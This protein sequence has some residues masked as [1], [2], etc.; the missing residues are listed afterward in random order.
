MSV[1]RSSTGEGPSSSA[2]GGASGRLSGP[3]R[4]SPRSLSSGQLVEVSFPIAKGL[5]RQHASGGG[6]RFSR[7]LSCST[8]VVAGGGSQLAKCR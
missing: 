3:I 5:I 7:L 6:H 8:S 1:L 4:S 2:F